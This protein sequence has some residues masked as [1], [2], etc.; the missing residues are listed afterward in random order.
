MQN[1]SP[2]FK[3]PEQ[4][5]IDITYKIWEEQEVERIHEWYAADCPVR[6]PGGVSNT[7]EEV[8]NDTLYSMKIF[9]NRDL[10][11]E[12]IIIG[13]LAEGFLSSHRVRSVGVHKGDGYLGP[14][15]N[16]PVTMLAIADCLCR[17]NQVVEEWVLADQARNLIQLGIDP[18][19]YGK[20][21]GKN[22]REAYAIGN[23]A[24]RER[25]ANPEGLT[26]VGDKAIAQRI[27]D[28]YSAIWN[29]KNLAVMDERYDRA[30]RFE[31]PGVEPNYGR[32]NTANLLT[33]MLASIPDGRF[34]PHY[35]IVRQQEERP[36]RVA[37][38][39]TVCGTHSGH[40]RY[41]DPTG[42]PVAIL[43]ISHFEL[44]DGL[45]VNEWFVMDEVAVYAQIAAYS[46]TDHNIKLITQ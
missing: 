26:I 38:R 2:E 5:I 40:G 36:V 12:D 30:L 35:I 1:F 41:G 22:N 44:R 28:T 17:N 3:T 45:I 27:M 7:A 33:S 20:N 31:G 10:L 29:D 14:A 37:L 13:D 6:T 23:D 11:A 24:M 25:W 32:N 19:A 21:V 43:G 18:L 39:W 4:Y 42:S 34:E 16:R 8:I 9:P 15:T 46:Q